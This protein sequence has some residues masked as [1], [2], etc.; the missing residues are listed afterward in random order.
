MF[1][2]S[3]PCETLRIFS[4]ITQCYKHFLFA[5]YSIDFLGGITKIY[6]SKLKPIGTEN[7]LFSKGPKD[8]AESTFV[9]IFM[10]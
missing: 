9:K 1:L 3:Q 4:I 10:K 5:L 8:G 7:Q 2:V 6:F